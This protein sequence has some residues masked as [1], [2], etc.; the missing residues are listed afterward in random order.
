MIVGLQTYVY[1]KP[2]E[3]ECGQ[4]LPYLNIAYHTYGKLNSAKNNVIWVCHALTGN[5][6]AA[7]WWSGLVG[8]GKVFDPDKHFI[9]CANILGSCYGA[10][11]A[12][13]IDPDTDTPYLK[14]FPLIT[15][16]DAVRSHQLLKM[17]LGIQ[18]IE[19]AIGGSTGGQQALEWSIIE[20]GSINKAVLI[21]CNAVHSPWGKA[22]NESQRMALE[23][24]QTLYTV[25]GGKAGLEAARSIGMI[26]YR[27]YETYQKTQSDEMSLLEGYRAASYQRYQGEKLSSRF[28]A[29]AYHSLTRTMDSHD[30]GRNRDSITSVLKTILA[31]TL[32]IGIKTDILFPVEEQ[33]FL[34]ENIPRAELRIIDSPYG[35]DGFL[36]E[37]EQMAQIIGSFISS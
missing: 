25:D 24:D 5:S 27:N 22:F 31:K 18:N 8:Q 2:F 32:V 28:K 6:D 26:S 35:H 30:V 9:V 17:H 7:D 20:P 4:T 11:N 29:L 21:A 23:A 37:W 3:L 15:I 12:Y 10:S 1:N 36:I 19:V 16:R 33:A 13:D 14:S 34:A